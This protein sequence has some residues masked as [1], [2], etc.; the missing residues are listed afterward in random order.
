[1][2]QIALLSACNDN[3]GS[4]LQSCAFQHYMSM[5]GID[6]E[7][8][9]YTGRPFLKQILRLFHLPLVR[10]KTKAMYRDW[11]CRIFHS[12]LRRQLLRRSQRFA[13]FRRNNLK[14]APVIADRAQLLRCPDRYDVFIVGSDQL[15]NPINLGTDFFTL[16][17]VPDEMLK[18]SYATSFGVDRI[19]A[20]LT[21]K[22][23][24]YLQR[25]DE[26][27]TREKSGQIIIRE[28]AGRD[29]PLVCDPT[30]LVDR[31]FWDRIK[32]TK[33]LVEGKYIF[34]YFI[35]ARPDIRA[36]A[37]EIGRKTGLRIVSLPHID[38]FVRADVNF[39][40]VQLFDVGPAEFVNLIANAAYILTDSFHGTVF[41]VLYEK[42]FFT[43]NRFKREGAGSMNSRISS[44]LH[45]LGISERRIDVCDD[46][47]R[48][49]GLTIDYDAV[50]RNL[51]GFRTHSLEYLR[52]L[53][54]LI[55][56]RL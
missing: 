14:I 32:G 31:T 37:K 54:L 42:L 56:N 9:V 5:L 3:Y 1:M 18:L 46:V 26:I 39:G 40:D 24:H 23:R 34:C 17:F 4:L 19:P 33:S 49:C 30:M 8:I 27:S 36:Y 52:K 21:A 25:F 16:N 45:V 13:D 47:E 28:I 29:V 15:W 43:F 22:Y 10:M 2:K 35:G 12:D 55:N 48:V 6:A 44:L 53:A 7:I 20:L 11:S 41:S 38:E 51:S 50:N